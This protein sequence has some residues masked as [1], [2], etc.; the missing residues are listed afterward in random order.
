MVQ[1]I[2]IVLFLPAPKVGYVVGKSGSGLLHIHQ[3]SATK[4][5]VLREDLESVVKK[6]RGI[7][8]R[9]V[10]RPDIGRPPQEMDGKRLCTI[11]G[12]FD[13]V[14][15]A[16]RLIFEMIGMQNKTPTASNALVGRNGC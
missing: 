1:D 5:N 15:I 2:T 7:G 9:V 4:V 14:L 11:V 12:T 3:A 6:M 16:E 10:A 8:H 13:N